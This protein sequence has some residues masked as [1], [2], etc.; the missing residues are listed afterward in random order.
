MAGSEFTSENL[1]NWCW[2]TLGSSDVQK[3]NANVA[4][5]KF[6]A[7]NVQN[8]PCSEHFRQQKHTSTGP[9]L[10]VGMSNICNRL[11]ARGAFASQNAKNMKVSETDVEKRRQTERQTNRKTGK[12]TDRQREKLMDRSID[13]SMDGWIDWWIGWYW[14][15]G[16]W[17][18]GLMD[19]WIDLHRLVDWIRLV[20]R[21][22]DR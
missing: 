11:W 4:R 19:W 16:W 6:P 1:K 15:I 5:S 20:E 12:E 9:R 3:M 13:R 10:E 22:V 2:T 7:Q 8:T 17:I 14:L 18:D 21:W